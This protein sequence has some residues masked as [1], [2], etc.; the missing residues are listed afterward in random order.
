MIMSNMESGLFPII[1]RANHACVPN[2][3]YIWDEE[4]QSQDCP[5]CSPSSVGPTMLVSL[6]VSTISS[7][8]SA[9]KGTLSR[10]FLDPFFEEKNSTWAHINRLQRFREIFLVFT[11]IFSKNGCLRSHWLRWHL[12]RVV[13]VGGWG[14]ESGTIRTITI[15]TKKG[16]FR[17]NIIIVLSKSILWATFLRTSTTCDQC[18]NP[19]LQASSRW[20]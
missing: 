2:C 8:L 5:N 13:V 9:S 7:R 20:G 18:H 6:T 1:C 3:I 10:D 17:W 4:N 14:V 15:V 16:Y 12:F 19:D 11:K